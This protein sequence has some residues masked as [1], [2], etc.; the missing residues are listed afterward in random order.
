MTKDGER[1]LGDCVVLSPPKSVSDET[2]ERTR[3]ALLKLKQ[4]KDARK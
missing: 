4:R 3:Q 1:F 2:K